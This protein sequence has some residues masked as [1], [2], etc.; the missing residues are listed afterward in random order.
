MGAA[1]PGLVGLGFIRK[2]VEQAVSSVPSWSLLRAQ[3][4]GSCLQFLCWVPFTMN[5]KLKM[6][7]TFPLHVAFDHG[8]NHGTPGMA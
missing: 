1:T 6:I 2:V 3:P 7:N 4:P 8:V 5:C